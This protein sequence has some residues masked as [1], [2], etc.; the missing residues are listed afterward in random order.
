MY[1][2]YMHSE[3]GAR[4][5]LCGVETQTPPYFALVLQLCKILWSCI[6]VVVFGDP[7]TTVGKHSDNFFLFSPNFLQDI[8]FPGKGRR[9]SDGRTEGAGRGSDC[10]DHCQRVLTFLPAQGKWSV[11]W[12]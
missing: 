8:P 2:Y 7:G 4:Q 3:C 10:Q 9:G 6:R 12:C 5:H 1:K 11:R